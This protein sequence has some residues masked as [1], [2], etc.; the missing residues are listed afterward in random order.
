MLVVDC[1]TTCGG[2]EVKTDEW[3]AA[4]TVA[5][6]QKCLGIPP[7]LSTVVVSEGTEENFVENPPLYLDLK[8]Y[9]DNAGKDEPST[10]FTPAIS[11]VLGLD[12]ALK[13]IEEEG[14]ETRIERHRTASDAMRSAITALGC[15]L[16][17]DL[18]NVSRYSNTVNA[19]HLPPGISPSELS[20]GMLKQG[21]Q[22][23]GGQNRI[24]GK[25]F[26]I[27]TMGNFTNNDIIEC[28]TALDT[29]LSDAGIGS[30]GAGIAE[31]N[32]ILG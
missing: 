10:P 19:A 18:N 28:I 9:L 4:I 14:M 6:S 1:I 12:E 26:R 20:E 16:F 15:E 7:G 30:R 31:A 32:R 2:D 8:S 22:I 21:V 23:S 27:A 3:G 13:M 29:V 5:G 17:P 24:K 11:L 25:I